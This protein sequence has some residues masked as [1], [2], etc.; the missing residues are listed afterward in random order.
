MALRR[1]VKWGISAL[2]TAYERRRH[3]HHYILTD[4]TPWREIARDG[5]MSVRHYTLPANNQKTVVAG[6][7][8]VDVAKKKHRIPL[9]LVPALGIHS[10]TYDLMPTRSMV[11]YYIAR[12][13]DVY[14]IDWGNPSQSNRETNLATYVNEWMPQA[15]EAV[16]EHTGEDQVN[17]VGYCMGGLLALMYLGGHEDAPVRSL[18]TIASPVNFHRGGSLGMV[19]KLISAPALKINELFRI[20]LDPFDTRLF[21]IPGKLVSV[22]FKM[23][24]PPGVVKSYLNLV[25]NITDKE[26]VTGHM[27]MGSWFNDMVD[28]P[29][30]TVREIIAKMMISNSMANDKIAVGDK[31]VRFSDIQQD[32]LALAGQTDNICTLPSARDIM[33]VIGSRDKRFEIMPGGHAGVFAGNKAPGSTWRSIADWLEPRAN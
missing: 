1:R 15:V 8:E 9:I 2:G 13:H 26:F 31:T 14:L 16:L 28:Y 25:K 32:L 5:I 10:W 21:H 4:K 19:A 22:G 6:D 20:N 3:P 29:G 24:N 18:A 33:R 11:R 27:S 23:T 12:G 30:A 7:Q 17:M